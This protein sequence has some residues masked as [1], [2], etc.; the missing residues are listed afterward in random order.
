VRLVVDTATWTQA[1]QA[2]RDLWWLVTAPRFWPW[3]LEA[4]AGVFGHRLWSPKQ[5]AVVQDWLLAQARAPGALLSA[6][7]RS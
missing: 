5:D 4:D 1:P 7:N 6:V 2:W 3:D